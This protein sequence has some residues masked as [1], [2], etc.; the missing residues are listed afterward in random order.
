MSRP[1]HAY[2]A[3]QLLPQE[4]ASDPK[5]LLDRL[6]PGSAPLT[7]EAKWQNACATTGTAEGGPPPRLLKISGA[8]G[9]RVA[10]L[11]K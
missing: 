3:K 1:H 5:R 4:L 11:E 2:F 9:R 7:L 10:I 8:P 6:T